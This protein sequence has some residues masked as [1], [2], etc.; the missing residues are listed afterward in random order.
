MSDNKKIELFGR[1]YINDINDTKNSLLPLILQEPE[2][3][4]V[5]SLPTNTVSAFRRDLRELG[6]VSGH[7]P[8]AGAAGATTVLNLTFGVSLDP[9]AV[10]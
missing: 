5:I 1:N 2:N 3:T 10:P 4:L 9:L 6:Q 8:Q 7:N